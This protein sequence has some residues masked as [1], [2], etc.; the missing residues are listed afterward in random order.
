MGIKS[1]SEVRDVQVFER[2]KKKKKKKRQEKWV[3]WAM[4]MVGQLMTE[5][6]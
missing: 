2:A 6:R 3:S 1:S 5:S 4:P